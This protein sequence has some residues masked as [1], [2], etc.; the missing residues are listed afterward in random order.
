[1]TIYGPNSD[2]PDFSIKVD[3]VIKE[4]DNP[5]VIVIKIL[6]LLT[7]EIEGQNT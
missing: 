1:M 2:T 4:F 6:K 3:K 7:T 5:N